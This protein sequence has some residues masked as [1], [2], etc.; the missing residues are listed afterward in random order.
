MVRSFNMGFPKNEPLF[1]R[2]FFPN[3]IFSTK[4]GQKCSL[5]A[6]GEPL[7]ASRL[8][9]TFHLKQTAW[10]NIASSRKGAPLDF[11]FLENRAA[12]SAQ[13]FSN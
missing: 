13:L 11:G 10:F 9:H 8:E 2:N 12:F 1:Q 3:E 7:S 4:L 5:V 6:L